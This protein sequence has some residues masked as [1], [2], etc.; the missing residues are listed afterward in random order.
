MSAADF[1]P[2]WLFFLLCAANLL[3]LTERVDDVHLAVRVLF[4][5]PE[6]GLSA[7]CLLLCTPVKLATHKR[8]LTL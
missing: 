6:G 5:L 2:S 3:D 7:Y 8:P 1:L 4:H